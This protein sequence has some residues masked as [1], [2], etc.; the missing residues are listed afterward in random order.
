[1]GK[2]IAD[3]KDYF[4]ARPIKVTLT[5]TGDG[6]SVMLGVGSL[7]WPVGAQSQP[8]AAAAITRPT[9][10]E[11]YVVT[12]KASYAAP[13]NVYTSEPTVTASDAPNAAKL[14]P[15]GYRA[16]PATNWTATQK[17]TVNTRDFHWNGTAWVLGAHP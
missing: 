7:G 15:L 13:G 8:A 6:N 16:R 2:L 3:N 12:P 17:I 10:A 5:D 1:M 14:T 11:T 9:T 4:T